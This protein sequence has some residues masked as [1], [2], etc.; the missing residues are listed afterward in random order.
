MALRRRKNKAPPLPPVCPMTECMKLLGGAWTPNVVWRLSAEPRR[1]S[2]LR[3]DIPKISAKV[4]SA[5]LR[6]L[7]Q[8]GV[9]TRTVENYDPAER[10]YRGVQLTGEK[11]FSDNWNAGLSYTWSRTTGNHFDPTFSSL[12]DYLNADCRTT[13]DLTVGNNGIIPCAE[14][15]NGANKSGRPTYDRPHNFKA[16]AAYVRP[17]GPVNLTVGALTEVLSKFRYQKERT[18][19]VLLPGT[20]TNQGSTATYYYNERGTDP[21]DGMEWFMDTSAEA[22]WKLFSTHSVGFKAEIFN[23]TNSR[24]IRRPE[25]TNL[26]FNFDGTVQS[27]FG[28]PRQAQLGVRLTF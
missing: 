28:D 4:L 27:G 18:V 25:V 19:N 1:F 16:N 6:A 7:E 15:N 20:L 21:V 14:V 5:R 2:E 9:I 12:G 10:K 8:N 23:I 24:N 17:I 11:R 22:T 26:I 13:V 3:D